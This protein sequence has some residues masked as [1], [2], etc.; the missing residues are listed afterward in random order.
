MEKKQRLA[1]G[2]NF[3]PY[4]IEEF[5]GRGGMGEVYVAQ[6]GVLQRSCAIK[7]AF[8]AV[9]SQEF[10]HRLE[11]E[12]KALAA[13]K[14]P[15]IVEV[16][17]YGQID[18]QPYIAMEFVR[19][20]GLDVLL[21]WFSPFT[22]PESLWV[23]KEL[24]KA[25]K[26]VHDEGLVHRDVKPAN[27]MVSFD[28]RLR[29]MDF[30]L[31]LSPD[32]TK[33]T[34]TGKV[35]GTPEYIAPE[36]LQGLEPSDKT[37]CYHYGELLFLCLKGKSL[38]DK[39]L[40]N[41]LFLQKTQGDVDLTGRLDDGLPKALR[42][43]IQSLLVIEPQ[44]RPSMADCLNV[45]RK[46]AKKEG[47]RPGRL[48]SPVN[49]STK[50]LALSTTTKDVV[51]VPQSEPTRRWLFFFFLIVFLF[52]VLWIAEKRVG[53]TQALS[54][55]KSPRREVAK[56][57]QEPQLDSGPGWVSLSL[58]LNAAA[59]VR[60]FATIDNGKQQVKFTLNSKSAKEHNLI[61][62]PIEAN[63]QH[64][65]LLILKLES[66]GH[67]L[68]QRKYPSASMSHI[69]LRKLIEFN[70]VTF[71]ASAHIL[72]ERL[73]VSD[74]KGSIFSAP[75]SRARN[76]EKPVK[77]ARKIY[78]F[79]IDDD[80]TRLVGVVSWQGKVYAAL[81]GD[82]PSV[83]CLEFSAADSKELS[84][85]SN[86]ELP[87]PKGQKLRPSYRAPPIVHGEQLFF[88]TFAD[89]ETVIHI[90]DL[91]RN[92]ASYLGPIEGISLIPSAVIAQRVFCT[93]GDWEGKTSRTY[94]FS[95][96]DRKMRWFVD[97]EKIHQPIRFDGKWL[98]LAD[99]K[100][101]YRLSPFREGRSDGG[102]QEELGE[103]FLAIEGAFSPPLISQGRAYVGLI[104]VSRYLLSSVGY[105]Q[106]A[107]FD[108]KS[109]EDLRYCKEKL[110]SSPR[111]SHIT[112][113]LPI[114]VHRDR[115]Y[116]ALGCGLY[117]YSLD[118]PNDYRGL[119]AFTSARTICRQDNLVA[120]VSF[121]TVYQ[122]T[123]F[124]EMEK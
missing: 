31:V 112:K 105:P 1:I 89:N 66:Q 40:W 45:I 20:Q 100:G 35:V 96:V 17:D 23:F 57:L 82:P 71:H 108:Y 67:S 86:I 104:K 43:L 102:L 37:D 93:V 11:H 10:L 49:E 95:R 8:P 101:L 25:I 22:L 116:F 26:A 79:P 58:K 111:V 121:K 51:K 83:V 68:F 74:K 2:D 47:C 28:G 53:T 41:E 113:S 39:V 64:K 24:A 18:G 92:K 50:S 107:S 54:P 77:A 15:N 63:L 30:G 33:I 60:A 117:S 16:F 48:A 84:I 91:K 76:Q 32:S 12:G 36:T 69:K 99:G 9:V 7:L 73:I 123:L 46:I 78:Q 6:H 120:L 29:L 4:I 62:R 90:V 118:E 80:Y 61:F 21:R 97:T 119:I 122:A 42:D 19:G 3:G 55:G 72:G 106:L 70:G 81:T 94:A 114:C 124:P 110:F 14:H 109:L 13:L 115:A 5:L 34:K 44:K 87:C 75:W 56:L 27:I 103:R 52:I 85:I 65:S 59:P 38:W 88:H 98:W